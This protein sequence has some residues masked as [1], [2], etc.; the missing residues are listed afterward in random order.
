M[1]FWTGVSGVISGVFLIDMIAWLFSGKGLGELFVE[2][3]ENPLV[4]AI[5]D[6]LVG[7]PDWM[8][9]IAVG[10]SIVVLSGIMCLAVMSATVP[11]HTASHRRM[12]RHMADESIHGRHRT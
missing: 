7:I 5:V 3:Q 11:E 2:G 4:L 12:V 1:S 10:A 6:R 9:W 8:F